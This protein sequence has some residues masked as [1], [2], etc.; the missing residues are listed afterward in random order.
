MKKTK[1]FY[2][3]VAESQGWLCAVC[4][5]NLENAEFAITGWGLHHLKKRSQGGGDE[6]ENL[7]ACHNF[8]NSR[9]EDKSEFAKK[10]DLI[11]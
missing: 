9:I 10:L 7:V 4:L 1:E 6:R 8:C 2:F 5:T 3:E 11:Y